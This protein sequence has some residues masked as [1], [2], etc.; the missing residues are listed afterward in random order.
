MKE[1]RAK[2]FSKASL[3]L[4]AVLFAVS[5]CSAQSSN[6]APSPL[7]HAQARVLVQSLT[8]AQTQNSGSNPLTAAQGQIFASLLSFDGKDGAQSWY[9]SLTQG[10]NKNF[11]GTTAYGGANVYGT[12]FTIT[13]EG[14]LTTLY[15]F[16][17]RSGCADGEGPFGGLV[18]AT[19]GNFYGTTEGGGVNDSCINGCGTIFKISSGGV[20][21]TLYNFGSTD[22]ANPNAGLVQATNGAFYGTTIEGGASNVGTIFKITSGGTLT[23]LHSFD[24]SDGEFPYA[25]LVQAT[26]GNFYGTTG[27]GGANGYG[28]VFT[29]TPEGALTTLYSFCA[30]SG[31]A[32]GEAPFGRLVQATDGSFYGTTNSG[33]ANNSCVEGCGTI[34]KISSGGVLTTL[35]NFGST[36]GAY[37][38]AGLVQGTNGAFYGTTTE[39]GA[40][41]VGTIFK[42]TSGS[43]LTTLHSFDSIDGANPY[44][45][46]LQ[47]TNGTFYGPTVGGGTSGFGTVFSLSVGLGPFVE[48]LPTSG[49]VGAIVRILGNNL[50]GSTSVTFNG[51][52]AAF[53]VRSATLITAA[54][55][56]GATSG[57]VRVTTPGGTLVSQV[58][59]RVR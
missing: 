24:Y 43:T 58:A 22:G 25:G 1:D 31:C 34:F 16:C 27:F 59:F 52:A 14:A 46:L 38:N 36:D 44:A 32:D 21:T 7:T 2:P 15:S 35:Y 57:T 12:V 56:S 18:E 33:G 40:S 4:W 13:P 6:V 49:K 50:K 10:T 48:S 20:L 39:G 17:A 3:F 23:T 53:V 30:R 11:Y 42:I 19:D 54:V 5:S 26:N 41:N 51:T 9:E 55:P 37:P 8:T 29:I 28:T 45:G 47:A